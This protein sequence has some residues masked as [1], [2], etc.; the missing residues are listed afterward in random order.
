MDL[1]K[2][3]RIIFDNVRLATEA[4]H[5]PEHSVS[6]IAVTKYVDSTIAGQLIDTG[7]EHIAENRVDKFLDKYE[8]LKDRSVTWHLIGTLQRRKVKDVIN[9]VDYFHALD[10]VKLA[11]EIEK[12]ADH[13]VKCF[14]QVNISEEDSKHGFKVSEIE[15]AIE[16]I[17]KMENIQLVGLMTMAPA[18]ASQERIASIFREANQL[19]KNLQSKKRK[20]MPFTELSMGM[21]GD[22]SIAIQEGSTFV[23]IGTSFFH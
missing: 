1:Q 6:V 21:S 14:L 12:R 3:K 23:R 19:R 10:S 9:F 16:E 13:P 5:R 18:D 11:S 2:N 8:A 17:G 22:Y 20:N 15:A 7:I 4:A